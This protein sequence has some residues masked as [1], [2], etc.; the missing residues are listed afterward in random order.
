MTKLLSKQETVIRLVDDTE[1]ATV[2]SWDN[3]LRVMAKKV[4]IDDLLV[5]LLDM[6]ETEDVV[7]LLHRHEMFEDAL[8]KVI[9]NY[10]GTTPAVVLSA[11][12][13]RVQ[14]EK[15]MPFIASLFKAIVEKFDMSK[16]EPK[17]I[18]KLLQLLL[19]RI[20]TLDEPSASD[21]NKLFLVLLENVRI[22]SASG[23]FVNQVLQ[24]LLKRAKL[25]QDIAI[26]ES[27]FEVLSGKARPHWIQKVLAPYIGRQKI[28]KTPILPRNTVFYQA[29]LDGTQIVC[30]EIDRQK[31]DTIYHK[32][33]YKSVG[34][35]KMLFVFYVNGEK[36]STCKVYAIKDI[37][38]SASTELYR[39]PFS[40]VHENFSTCWPDLYKFRLKQLN[41]LETLP[42]LFLKSPSNDHLYRGKNLR[43]L[44]STLQDRD[45]DDSLLE[46]TG[47]TFGDH[48]EMNQ[49]DEKPVETVEQ[50]DEEDEVDV[51][52]QDF[53]EFD[54][55][56]DP[57]YDEE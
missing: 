19:Y 44:F 52:D 31:I 14:V 12:L 48:F 23:D 4:N 13:E 28:V 1:V 47:L 38:L 9:E 42:L 7:E 22:T 43:E 20:T 51:D 10:S 24:E 53:D 35:P 18:A 2:E 21:F 5:N 46:R 49:H 33:S 39:F 50:L 32:D 41:Q 27:M 57:E 25:E 16:I 34:H 17:S 30:L 40:N 37:R 8:Q 45:F 3:G 29:Q 6:V 36:I 11:F 55:F 56:N 15:D 54:E 26:L